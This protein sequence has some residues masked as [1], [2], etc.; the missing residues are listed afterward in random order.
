MQRRQGLVD[1]GGVRVF[2]DE[3]GP[4]DGTPLL[5]VHGGP[6][7]SCWDLMA[8]V[9]DRLAE[10]GVRVI[11]V[12]Q[13][14]VLRSDPLPADPPLTTRLLVEDYERLRHRLDL[15]EWVVLGHSAGGATALDYCLAAPEAVRAVIFDCPIWDQVALD[16]GRLSAAADHYD[17]LGDPDSGARARDLAADPGAAPLAARHDLL[18]G[19]GEHYLSLFTHD[20]TGARAYADLL[21]Q[22][23]AHDDLDWERGRSHAPLVA[24][25]DTDRTRMLS[26]LTTP[27]LLVR[28]ESDLATPQSLLGRYLHD[29]PAPHQVM[30]IGRAGHLAF[31]EQPGAYGDAV[32]G[33]AGS[34]GS[35]RS[36][37]SGG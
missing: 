34:V 19:L 8:A 21:A 1:I 32:A 23:E 4:V 7:Q 37:R 5:V 10:R 14:G 9:G 6:G 20:H 29:V 35:L 18:R 33:F 11:G 22:T 2:V 16:R 15:G 28:G 3:R 31:V 12:D 13:R 26:R 27:S 17:R 30:T 24:D 36:V 25:L